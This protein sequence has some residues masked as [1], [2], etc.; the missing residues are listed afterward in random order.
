MTPQAGVGGRFVESDATPQN[1][2]VLWEYQEKN[3]RAVDVYMDRDS[4]F[5]VAPR[6][7]KRAKRREANRLTQLGR[8]RPVADFPNH[9]TACSFWSVRPRVLS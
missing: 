6:R 1:M 3:G 9:P 2:A 5:T 7:Q 4:M 8:A